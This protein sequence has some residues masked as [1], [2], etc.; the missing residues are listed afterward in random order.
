MLSQVTGLEVV[1]LAKNNAEASSAI[2][3]LE[4]DLVVLDLQMPDG[5]G[6]G[7]LREAKL[8]Y[9]AMQVIVFTNHPEPQYKQRCRELGA[10]HFFCK[11]TESNLLIETAEKLAANQGAPNE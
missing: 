3:S 1:G 10:D 6:M 11:S 2:R 4:P 8:N 9:P 5:M 7:V